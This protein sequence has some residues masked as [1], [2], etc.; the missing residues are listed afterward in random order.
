MKLDSL[1]LLLGFAPNRPT[2]Q[3]FVFCGCIR[4]NGFVVTNPNFLMSVNDLLQLEL[5]LCSNMPYIYTEK[6]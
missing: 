4:I 3:E 6:H 2:A 1:A 5:D